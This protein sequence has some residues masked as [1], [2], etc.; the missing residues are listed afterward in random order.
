MQRK[1]P[2][3]YCHGFGDVSGFGYDISGCRCQAMPLFFR[4]GL[5][6]KAKGCPSDGQ[7]YKIKFILEISTKKAEDNKK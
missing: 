5:S 1:Q 3:F 6:R 2:F 7:H 4:Y